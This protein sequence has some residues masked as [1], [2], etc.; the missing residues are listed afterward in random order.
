VSVGESTT[1]VEVEYAKDDFDTTKATAFVSVAWGAEPCRD[2]RDEKRV[3]LHGVRA[4][5]MYA[6]RGADDHRIVWVRRNAQA[7]V[8][9]RG[10]HGRE[11]AL[12]L[13]Q[14]AAAALD[15][16]LADALVGQ[17][18]TSRLQ[19]ERDFLAPLLRDR[20]RLLER[21]ALR[22]QPD[23]RAEVTKLW[24]LSD[25]MTFMRNVYAKN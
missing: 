20:D 18:T 12:N 9:L 15:A 3:T 16:W 14:E 1:Q 25:P 4:R 23:A 10:V 21:E 8:L 6:P 17:L 11:P 7:A 2:H 5:V 13:L 24:H 22:Y 19:A